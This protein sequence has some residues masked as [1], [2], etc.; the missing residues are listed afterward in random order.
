M[1]PIAEEKRTP[2][3]ASTPNLTSEV[4]KSRRQ[5]VNIT[6]HSRNSSDSS[7]YHEL[8]SDHSSPNNKT[9]SLPRDRAKVRC[10]THNY[11]N[12]YG[13]VNAFYV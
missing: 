5:P 10:Y 4:P 7:G 6:N 2:M 8:P 11:L 3:Y 13:T 1:H 9:N 12:G